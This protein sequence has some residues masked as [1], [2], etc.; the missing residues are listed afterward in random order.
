MEVLLGDKVDLELKIYRYPM[1]IHIQI[2][3]ETNFGE[4]S[5]SYDFAPTL[6]NKLHQNISSTYYT[7]LD[8]LYDR[9][10][11][12]GGLFMGDKGCNDWM[13]KNGKTIIKKKPLRESMPELLKEF[14]TLL[15]EIE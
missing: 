9:H 2:L 5:H 4:I 8:E 10:K 11:A 1:N 7:L 13:N 12:R 6:E 3:I 15:E 14:K